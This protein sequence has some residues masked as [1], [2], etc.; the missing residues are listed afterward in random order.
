MDDAGTKMSDLLSNSFM[1]QFV[2]RLKQK[3]IEDHIDQ[4]RKLEKK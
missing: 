1:N 4:T 3:D 2:E